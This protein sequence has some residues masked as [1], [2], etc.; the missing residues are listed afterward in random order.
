MTEPGRIVLLNGTSS[1]GK[2]SIAAELLAG[3]PGP[4]FRLAVDDLNAMRAKAQT[5]ALDE[6]AL[7][8]T[9]RRT[10]AGFH[11]AVAGMAAAGNDVIM[12]HLLGEPWRLAD[13]LQLFQPFAVFFVGVHCDPA[14]LTRRELARGDRDPGTAAAQLGLVHAHGD[15]DLTVDTT[16]RS[17]ADCAADIL[18]A[19]ECP[20]APSAFRRLE[21]AFG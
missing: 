14:E 13:C 15:Y 2:S 5:L 6:P 10:R 21:T 18:H 8:E 3:W 19:L 7:T 17:A 11:R 20:P 16:H 12:D 4:A 1:S 9:L